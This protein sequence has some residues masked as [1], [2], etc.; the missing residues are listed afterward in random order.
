MF[1]VA[2]ILHKFISQQHEYLA[3]REEFWALLS[4]YVLP[5]V[6]L[7]WYRN[8]RLNGWESDLT[9]LA[10]SLSTG[11]GSG[12][13]ADRFDLGRTFYTRDSLGRIWWKYHVLHEALG[14]PPTSEQFL[15][16]KSS[17]WQERPEVY[18]YPPIVK[19]TANIQCDETLVKQLGVYL[20]SR[21]G[22]LVSDDELNDWGRAAKAESLILSFVEQRL[23]DKGMKDGLLKV[24]DRSR[25]ARYLEVLTRAREVGIEKL[26][27]GER[28]LLSMLSRLVFY[29]SY[30]PPITHREV[31]ENRTYRDL[32]DYLIAI[33]S[34]YDRVCTTIDE[35]LKGLSRSVQK[36]PTEHTFPVRG[37]LIGQYEG[38]TRTEI[39]A[40]FLA[41]DENAV[42]QHF[43]EGA[44]F[45]KTCG[46][47]LLLI[48]P[49]FD[50]AQKYVDNLIPPYKIF[51][52]AQARTTRDGDVFPRYKTSGSLIFTREEDQPDD[53]LY[54]FM[55]RGKLEDFTDG[56]P[57]QLTW[58]MEWPFGNFPAL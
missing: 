12:A 42:S 33:P 55:G 45:S 30:N 4:I 44:K 5:D 17:V 14:K 41:T 18:S 49:G 6:I 37:V 13:I 58:R 19:H 26:D 48:Q 23:S 2:K 22:H 40:L 54:Y 56:K 11:T 10:E 7:R 57:M 1:T 46:L 24:T 50:T 36:G 28:T 52:S 53:E 25:L 39:A 27:E 43:A 38:F 32:A 15:R 3:C 34:V 47:D 35:R 21:D 20:V 8:P 51:C 31:F 29:R 9:K 16:A